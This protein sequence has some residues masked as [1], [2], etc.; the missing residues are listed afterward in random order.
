MQRA[1]KAI[2]ILSSI[3][4]FA[5]AVGCADDGQGAV[6]TRGDPPATSNDQ[7]SNDR[8]DHQVQ[9]DGG[10]VIFEPPGSVSNARS[11]D[12]AVEA[13]RSNDVYG[14]AVSQSKTSPEVF[15]ALYTNL[16]MGK[17]NPDGTI[18]PTYSRVPVWVVIYHG[19]ADRGA[20]PGDPPG[21]DS[22][23]ADIETHDIKFIVSDHTG[24]VLSII[25]EV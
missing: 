21:K 1:V 18:N 16:S 9:A 4:T 25:S 14:P 8:L 3:P 22:S 12:S 15:F 5:L 10:N 17:A 11:H 6:G 24:E 7:K 20:G 2:I 23:S 19:I 13:A